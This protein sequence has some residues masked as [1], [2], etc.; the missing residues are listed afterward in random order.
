MECYYAWNTDEDILLSSTS[1]GIFSVLAEYVLDKGGTVYG[2]YLDNK[3]LQVRH[4]SVS[5]I[6]N[7]NKLRGSK[8]Q[9]SNTNN[10]FKTIESELKCNKWVLFSGTP[11]QCSG[12]R[13]FLKARKIQSNQLICSEVLCHGVTNSS[14]VKKYI[15]SLEKKKKRRVNEL[16]F[17]N[18]DKPWY[19]SGSSIRAVF[20]DGLCYYGNHMTDMFYIAYTGNLILRPSCYVCKYASL[21]N[22]YSDFTIGD[23]WGAEE[24]INNK[25]A[26]NNGIGIVLVNTEK[27]TRIW[28][29]IISNG[30]VFAKVL[31]INKAIRRNGALIK[32]ARPNTNR[33]EFF[34]RIN[35][36]DFDLVVRDYFRKIIRKKKILK[37]IGYNN[38]RRLRKLK[39]K[40][41]R[42]NNG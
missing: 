31:D 19:H 12:L 29:E 42:K 15:E 32:P 35:D 21:E 30:K 22:R 28:S 36:E 25:K 11:C 20:E 34:C 6:N 4:I 2:A 18:K 5:D 1:G 24:Y 33:E 3:S 39:K 16:Y 7:L 8:Y 41:L 13:S 38:V 40:I 26:L 37:F 10:V 23:F 27:A 17:R 14:V 9:Q